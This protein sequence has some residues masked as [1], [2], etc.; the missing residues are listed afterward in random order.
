M[1]ENGPRDTDEAFGEHDND[2]PFVGG[3]EADD[4]VRPGAGGRRPAAWLRL[5]Y[6]YIILSGLRKSQFSQF[7]LQF[8]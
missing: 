1:C 6:L 7:G 8:C 4:Q 5:S 3:G 2:P